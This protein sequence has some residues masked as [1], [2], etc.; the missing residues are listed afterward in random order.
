[1][2]SYWWYNFEIYSRIPMNDT[3]SPFSMCC[4]NASPVR[5]FTKPP[6]CTLSLRLLDGKSGCFPLGAHCDAI[7]GSRVIPVS[8]KKR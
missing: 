7:V 4:M 1:M 8:S 3:E 5:G 6:R 2:V